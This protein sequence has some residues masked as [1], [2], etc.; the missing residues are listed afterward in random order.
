L[1]KRFGVQLTPLR[2]QVGEFKRRFKRIGEPFKRGLKRIGEPFK[3][4]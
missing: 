1:F 3:R 2:R 4:A